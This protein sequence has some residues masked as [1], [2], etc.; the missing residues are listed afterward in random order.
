MIL[1][2]TTG[3]ASKREPLAHLPPFTLYRT[4]RCCM[5]NTLSFLFQSLVIGKDLSN[6]SNVNVSIH[7]TGP[8]AVH[9]LLPQARN[10]CLLGRCYM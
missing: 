4:E 5:H 9:L 7:T 8:V 6:K 3:N 2:S 10:R 1:V